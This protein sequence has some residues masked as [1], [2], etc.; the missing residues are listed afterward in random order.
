MVTSVRQE[1][2][3]ELEHV[4]ELLNTWLIPNDTREPADK[5][6][7]FAHERELPA[8]ARHEVQELRDDLRRVVERSADADAI[9]TAWIERAGVRTVVRDGWVTFVTANGIAG[10]LVETVLAAIVDGTWRR[11]KAC[12]DCRWVFYDHTRNGGKRWCMMNADGAGA[13][14]CGTIA[15]VRRYRERHPNEH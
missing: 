6:D 15:K 4:R 3:G 11:L 12:P 5:F 10:S 7:D 2:P 13:R 1:A 14:G 8:A 9:L